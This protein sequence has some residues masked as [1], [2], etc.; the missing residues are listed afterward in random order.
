MNAGHYSSNIYE[1]IF[2]NTLCS[3][4]IDTNKRT[5]IVDPRLSHGR[6]ESIKMRN[7]DTSRYSL[8]SEIEITFAVLEEILG[9]KCIW[10]E[11]D[12]N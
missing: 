2:E 3:P 10:S 4:V 12:R 5:G 6:M 1:Y 9:C 11:R 8:R 7:E